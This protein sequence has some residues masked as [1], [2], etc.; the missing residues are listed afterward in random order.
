M[1]EQ[2]E[3]IDHQNGS[4]LNQTSDDMSGKFNSCNCNIYIYIFLL[5]RS[6]TMSCGATSAIAD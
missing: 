2:E 1:K 4:L 5:K 3:V 6:I